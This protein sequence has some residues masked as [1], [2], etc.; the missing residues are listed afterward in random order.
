MTQVDRWLLPDGIGELLPEQAGQIE[1][2]RRQ[3]LDLYGRWGYELVIPPL[4]EFTESLLVGLGA[5]IDLQTF[6]I[7]DQ[8]SGRLMGIRADITPQAARIDAHSLQREGVVRLCYAGS[9]LH[10]RPKSPMAS[11]SPIQVGAELYGDDSTHSDIEIVSL[12]L[13]TL[14]VVGQHTVTLDTGHVGVFAAVTEAAGLSAAQQNALIELLAGKSLPPVQEF[15]AALDVSPRSAAQLEAL[16]DL[17]GGADVLA[18]GRSLFADLPPALQAITEIEQ[19]TATIAQRYPGV[20]FFYDL[21]EFRGWHYHTGLV[22]SAL[23]PD[24]NDALAQGGRYN[25]IGAAFGR[26]RPATGFSVDLKAL[27]SVAGRATSP[28][29]IISAPA[30]NDPALWQLVQQLRA[31]GEVVVQQPDSAGAVT[32][33][34]ITGGKGSWQL[35][36]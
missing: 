18:T 12:M 6:R 31:K 7:T 5:D 27:L 4:V 2:I 11:R 28:A 30:D 9:T 34:R 13:E 10:T 32:G 21:G 16:V 22:F 20:D 14:A 1:A 36:G 24:C 25:D 26:A 35:E 19:L 33:R 29:D 3:L 23:V 17:N 15:I 8:L